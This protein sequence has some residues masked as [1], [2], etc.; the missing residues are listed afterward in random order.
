MTKAG[1]PAVKSSENGVVATSPTTGAAGTAGIVRAG[2]ESD[3]PAVARL[4]SPPHD[5]AVLRWL[6]D[7]GQGRSPHSFVAAE[8]D[9]IV[10][11]NGYTLSRFRTRAGEVT[12]L[13]CMHW[14]MDGSYR[15]RGLGLDVFRA[16]FPLADFVYVCGGTERSK[17]LF[18]QMGFAKPFDLLQLAKVTRPLAW[19]R[20]QQGPLARRLLKAAVLGARARMTR[21]AFASRSSITVQPYDP[22]L[23]P[24]PDRPW[25]AVA[26]VEEPGQIDWFLRCPV[27][28]AQAFHIKRGDSILGL[29]VCMVKEHAP[30]LRTGRIVHLSYL[31]EDPGVWRSSLAAVEARLVEAGCSVISV[32]ASHPRFLAALAG[33]GFVVRARIPVWIREPKGRLPDEGW[34]LTGIEGDLG[35]RRV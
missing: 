27:N 7:A 1:R 4:Y 3:L 34:H 10:G 9:R 28:D 11:H 5:L 6:L 25:P 15:G 13:H 18:A 2:T 22:R 32:F 35:H 19:A 21:P 23:R 24:A 31:G 20:T 30:G 17:A 33:R 26:N 12:G 29:A 14:I 8:G 16:T